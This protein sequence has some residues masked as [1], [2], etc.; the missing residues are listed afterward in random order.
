MDD[1]DLRAL[2]ATQGHVFRRSDATHLSDNEVRRRIDSGEWTRCGRGVYVETGLVQ[3][4][5]DDPLRTH[6]LDIAAARLQLG[7][8]VA[9]SHESAA[10]LHGVALLNPIPTVP[11][12]TARRG[13]PAKK[14]YAELEV[15]EL[16]DLDV[17]QLAGGPA[18]SV[19]R[20]VVD[21]CRERPFAAGVVTADSALFRQQCSADE[22]DVALHRC[23][24]WPGIKQARVAVAFA[25]A[26]AESPLESLCRV[27]CHEGELPPPEPQLWIADERG[28]LFAR[29]DLGWK[30]Q[31]T[32]LEGDGVLKYRGFERGPTDPLAL[33]KI[34]QHKLEDLG[35]EVVRAMWEEALANRPTIAARVQRAFERAARRAA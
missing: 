15:A 9:A 33:E 22:L 13:A 18:T 24:G 10:R 17:V 21:L 16:Q 25:D 26:R 11:R 32:L 27:A 14:S 8:W 30:D 34:R 29:A 3:S 5:A 12:F 4:V 7:R 35:W 19:A 6:A 31:R 2:A 1:D 20:T 23:A 28:F